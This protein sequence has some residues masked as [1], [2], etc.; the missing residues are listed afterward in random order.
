MAARWTR[1]LM[2]FGIVVTAAVFFIALLLFL[3]SLVWHPQTQS[4][5]PAP[6]N[7]F[8][9]PAPATSTTPVITSA[10]P[11]VATVAPDVQRTAELET[12]GRA[13]E[14]YRHASK[15]NTYPNTLATLVQAGY[16]A[17]QPD[18]SYVYYAG[19]T[20]Y[21]VCII[22]DGSYECVLSDIGPENPITF[23]AAAL[24]DTSY[25]AWRTLGW[26]G[27]STVL[28][29]TY[30]PH[31][32]YSGDTYSFTLSA[33][34]QGGVSEV[35]G[36]VTLTSY[37]L[38]SQETFSDL[39]KQLVVATPFQLVGSQQTTVSGYPAYKSLIEGVYQNSQTYDGARVLIDSGTGSVFQL[40][41]LMDRTLTPLMTSAVAGMINLLSLNIVPPSTTH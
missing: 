20:Y 35:I 12:I 32:T 1:I 27:T 21:S 3:V 5:S 41:F 31:W 38:G 13:L 23:S 36:S 6:V 17:T 10:P 11:S 39:Q 9:S 8:T 2:L 37:E 33:T 16:L 40:D 4:E 15:N 26:A 29:I 22:A 24:D 28:R 30:P 34:D 19:S 25:A 7:P 18:P 14:T